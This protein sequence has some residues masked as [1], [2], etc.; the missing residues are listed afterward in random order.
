M[1]HH[2]VD[3][4]LALLFIVFLIVTPYF[5]SGRFSQMKE[6]PAFASAR[7]LIVSTLTP[8]TYNA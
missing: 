1:E 8:T 6:I 5:S 3:L 4:L 7:K 2:R